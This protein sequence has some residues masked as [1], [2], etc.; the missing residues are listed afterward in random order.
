MSTVDDTIKLWDAATGELHATLSG[1]SVCMTALAFSPN[2]RTLVS[3]GNKPYFTGEKSE[4]KVWEVASGRLTGAVTRPWHMYPV[5]L[6]FGLEDL[7]RRHGSEIG[8]LLIEP[9]M[10][11]CCSL[12]ATPD[13][14]RRIGIL[15]SAGHSDTNE[16][17]RVALRK[18]VRVQFGLMLQKWRW[19]V[20][21]GEIKPDQYNNAWWALVRQYQGLVPPEARPADAFDPGAKMHIASNIDYIRYFLADVL[22]FQIHSAL[23]KEAGCTLPLHRCSLFGSKA[24]GMRWRAALQMGNSR[25]WTDVL[26]AM[27][28]ERRISGQPIRDYLAPLEAWLKTKTERVPIGWN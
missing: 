13:Y 21:S 18:L 3:T 26:E 12:T 19:A 16:L 4:V 22:T 6:L 23:S 27:T 24:A 7:L 15:E 10:G 8:A 1:H 20:Q 5:G 25:P 14:L 2:G 11:N 28:G 9:I 17:L